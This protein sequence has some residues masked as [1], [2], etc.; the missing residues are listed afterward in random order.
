MFEGST[1]SI[2]ETIDNWIGNF[3][4]LVF[5]GL[6]LWVVYRLIPNRKSKKEDTTSQEIEKDMKKSDAKVCIKIQ[7]CGG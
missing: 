6:C 4:Q 7:W 3:V 1:M 2:G 5:L